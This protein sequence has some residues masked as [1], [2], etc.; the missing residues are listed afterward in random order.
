MSKLLLAVALLLSACQTHHQQQSPQQSILSRNTQPSSC[1]GVDY[2][3]SKNSE[4]CSGVCK[5]AGVGGGM[6]E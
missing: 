2:Q 6:C 4:C 3:C 1:L 5:P